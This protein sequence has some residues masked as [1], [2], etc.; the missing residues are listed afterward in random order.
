LGKSLY[1]LNKAN[2]LRGMGEIANLAI[3][4]DRP[5]LQYKDNKLYIRLKKDQK[6]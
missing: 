2:L 3:D 5:Q 1:L 4:R 6:R